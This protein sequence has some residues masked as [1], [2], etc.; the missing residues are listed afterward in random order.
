[1]SIFDDQSGCVL[2]Y[3]YQTH[4]P[5]G[6]M[7]DCDVDRRK[8]SYTFKMYSFEWKIG[9]GRK[10]EYMFTVMGTDLTEDVHVEVL[11]KMAEHYSRE[12]ISYETQVFYFEW[13]VSE[14][15]KGL[16]IEPSKGLF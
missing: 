12:P 15:F 6:S 10:N 3:F 7:W 9:G 14:C 5:D 13:L 16:K 8:Y 2:Q 4:A 11:R 1:M